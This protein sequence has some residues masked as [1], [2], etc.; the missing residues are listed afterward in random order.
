MRL[1]RGTL[2]CHFDLVSATSDD[3]CTRDWF[4]G[5]IWYEGGAKNGCHQPF[6]ISYGWDSHS[7]T[8]VRIF[9]ERIAPGIFYKQI[10]EEWFYD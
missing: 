6:T 4:R 8:S 5:I 1:S 2:Y 7:E 9:V 10:P 3:W